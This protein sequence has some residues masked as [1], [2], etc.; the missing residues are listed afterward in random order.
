[1]STGLLAAERQLGQ[2]D[3]WRLVRHPALWIS[4]GTLVMYTVA[5]GSATEEQFLLVG[6]GLVL[7]AFVA[8][9][10]TAMAVRRSRTQGADELFD[11]LPVDAA[12]RSVGHG[13]STL[14]A[15]GL[16]L[17]LTVGV[18]IYRRPGR[19]IGVTEDTIPGSIDIPR[20]TVAQALQG[21]MAVVVFCALGV[22][23]A[24]WVPAWLITIAL[25]VPIFMQFLWF[26]LWQGEGLQPATWWW[27]LASGWVHGE[28]FGCLS[29]DTSCLLEVQGFDTVT[30]WWHLGYLAALAVFLVMIAVLRHRRDGPAWIAFGLSGV[31]LVSLAA[32]Q[33]AVYERFV[34]LVGA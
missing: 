7:P 19:V 8:M 22:A 18:W 25:L 29:E 27:P 34:P 24:R 5:V 12:R 20:P 4:I 28:W 30:P 9:V 2:V 31:T 1:V 23:L 21:P 13:V 32:A 33:S 15:G 14:A 10:L 11:V 6:Y 17:A 3:G 16:A 26:G